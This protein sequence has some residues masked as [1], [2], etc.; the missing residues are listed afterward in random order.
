[1]KGADGK[2]VPMN[3]LVT[4]DEWESALRCGVLNALEC[5][6]KMPEKPAWTIYFARPG[7]K[8]AKVKR[9]LQR[10]EGNFFI[11]RD[12]IGKELK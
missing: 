9:D 3:K 12:S 11:G 6:F 4:E 5:G 10:I 7:F 2:W 1:L 8:F